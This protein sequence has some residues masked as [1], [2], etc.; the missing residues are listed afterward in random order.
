MEKSV[1]WE[2]GNIKKEMLSDAERT[3]QF[4]KLK[5]T[6]TRLFKDIIFISLGIL[7][8]GFGLKGFLLPNEF[9]DGGVTGIS[10]LIE[11]TTDYP[12]SILI[13]IINV[14]FIILGYF[15]IG[16]SFA[17]KSIIAIIGLAFALEGIDYPIITSDRLL[18][19]VFG[20]FFL[21]AGIGLSVRGGGVLD[22]TEVLAIYLGRK[23]GL[24]IGDLILAFNIVIFSTAAYLLSIETA[25]YSILTYLTAS[26]T[27]DFVIEGVEEYIGVTIISPLSEDV[28]I[29]I[30]ERM[31]RGVTIYDGKRGFGKRGDNLNRTDIIYTVITRLELNKLQTEIQKIDQ[32]AFIVMNSVKD[33]KGGMIKKRQFKEK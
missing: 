2:Q 27:V 4:S 28:R 23:T 30:I 14:P 1:P 25:L 15:Q 33:L 19:A 10:L 26:K 7:A 22:G 3:D 16:K 13:V 31:G 32:K 17:V 29:M 5:I 12:L 21:G 20:G 8:A 24:T 11:A 18:V 6:I 9:I